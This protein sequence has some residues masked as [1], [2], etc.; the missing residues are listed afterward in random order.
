MKIYTKSGDAGITQLFSGERVSKS[1][2]RV[3]LYGTVDELQSV[4]ILALNF[5]VP[6][7]IRLDLEAL[8]YELYILSADFATIISSDKNITRISE[9]NILG[10]E[11]KIDE[12]FDEL[13]KSKEFILSYSTQGAAFLNNARTVCRR[14]E[15]I[16]IAVNSSVSHEEELSKNSIKYLN[17]LSDFL[18]AAARYADYLSN[19]PTSEK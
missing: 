16:A 9:K 7:K 11:Q 17:R 18:F 14:A 2:L 12:Y 8:V 1:S 19:L 15:R 10:L 13:P 6:E 5:G 3:E 4:V